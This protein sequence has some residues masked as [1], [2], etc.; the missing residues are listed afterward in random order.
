MRRRGV[1]HKLAEMFATGQTPT[2][3]TDSTF[4]EGRWEQ[5]YGTPQ[6]RE[7]YKRRA[8]REGVDVSGKIY[9]SQLANFPGDPEAWVSG[10]GDVQRVCEKRGWGCAGSVN[11]KPRN[12]DVAPPKDIDVADD[13]IDREVGEILANV[14]DRERVDVQDLREQVRDKRKPHW[15]K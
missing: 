6:I 8:A 9:V 7:A 2:L 4:F 11:V 13:I 12:A 1:S 3:N 5:F 15:S 14:P 10:R